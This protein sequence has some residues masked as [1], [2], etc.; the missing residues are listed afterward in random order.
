MILDWEYTGILPYPGPL[1]RF[2]AFGEENPDSLF[3]MTPEDKAFALE[4]YY[5][6][7]IRSKGISKAA[8][9]R[10]MKL[11]FFAE[12]CEWMCLAVSSGD[13]TSPKYKKYAPPGP[14]SRP[15]AVPHPAPLNPPPCFL[16]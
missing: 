10:T 11:F 9:E 8:Y 5:E 3:Q 2:L 16:S 4:Y 6:N 13:F 12:Y 15:R 14:N 1:A 7:L